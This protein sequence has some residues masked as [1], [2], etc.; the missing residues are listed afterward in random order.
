[1]GMMY[2]TADWEQVVHK[3]ENIEENRRLMR[4]LTLAI[5]LNSKPFF[6]TGLKYFRITLT[7]VLKV[8]YTKN[9]NQD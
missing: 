7:T 6:V 9:R 2:Y 8:G 4:L 3:S 1:M 5:Q